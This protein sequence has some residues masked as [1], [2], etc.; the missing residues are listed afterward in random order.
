M[1]IEKNIPIPESAGESKYPFKDM[2]VG[3]SVFVEGQTS[4]GAA[5]MSAKNIERRYGVKF[6]AR[7][8]T[9]DGVDGVRIWR[10]E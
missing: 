5:M 3:D 4:Q 8:R 2:E 7:K 10:I 6:S 1:K 9:E